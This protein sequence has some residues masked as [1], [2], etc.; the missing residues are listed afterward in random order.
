ME[1][2]WLKR[3][4]NRM[5]RL[6]SKHG[7]VDPRNPRHRQASPN[8]PAPTTA[9]DIAAID[10]I[11]PPEANPTWTTESKQLSEERVSSPGSL[12]GA[13]AGRADRSVN[14]GPSPVTTAARACPRRQAAGSHRTASQTY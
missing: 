8:G 9:I 5:L 11:Q 6:A 14:V 2:R 7:A 1:R 4:V 10:M 13:G 3:G 12:C